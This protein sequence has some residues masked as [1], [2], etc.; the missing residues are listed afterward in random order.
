MD[1]V[2]MAYLGMVIG[3]MAL[4][5]IVLAYASWIAPGDKRS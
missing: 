3:S 5:A 2:E 4:F 1:S